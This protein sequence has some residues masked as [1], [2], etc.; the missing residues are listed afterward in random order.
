MLFT[1]WYFLCVVQ[2]HAEG[3]P[4]PTDSVMYLSWGEFSWFFSQGYTGDSLPN[5]FCLGRFIH[6]FSC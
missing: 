5:L 2:L 6:I 4:F 3:S 1:T